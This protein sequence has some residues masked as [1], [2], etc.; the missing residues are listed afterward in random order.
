MTSDEEDE[1]FR[2]VEEIT[3]LHQKYIHLAINRYHWKLNKPKPTDNRYTFSPSID[4]K[5]KR[6]I[7]KSKGIDGSSQNSKMATTKTTS[8]IEYQTIT[9]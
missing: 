5:S 8:H 1:H 2:S 6:M 9:L 7:Q 3:N 4:P